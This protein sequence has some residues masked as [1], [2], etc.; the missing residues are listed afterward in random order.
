MPRRFQFSLASILL[1]TT[2]CAL[3]LGL[4]ISLTWRQWEISELQRENRDLRLRLGMTPKR[5]HEA[6][7]RDW[8]MTICLSEWGRFASGRSWNL[9][10]NAAGESLLT[11]HTSPAD[12]TQSF[13]VSDAQLTELRKLLIRERFFQLADGYGE[14]VF[15]GSTTTITIALGEFAK[16][17]RIQYLMNWAINEP[18]KLR[19]P[20]RAVR[21]E[22]LIRSWLQH[23]EAVDSTQYNQ[24]ILD[25]VERLERSK[26]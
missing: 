23:P 16:T 7:I 24:R 20:A 13:Q 11:I 21:V 14:Q 4:V 19:E 15:D 8:P 9:S 22:M 12:T 17:V 18:E 2:C 3:A 25:A 6:V 1:V 5:I 26:P 10:V